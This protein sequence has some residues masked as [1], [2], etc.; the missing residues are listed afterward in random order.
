MSWT[1]VH[2]DGQPCQRQRKVCRL[3]SL[4]EPAVPDHLVKGG[5]V[6]ADRCRRLAR[7]HCNFSLD[8]CPPNYV[9]RRP[10]RS[11]SK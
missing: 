9:W 11:T 8:A 3:C 5:N 1:S 6:L 4:K 2:M 10:A 7:A